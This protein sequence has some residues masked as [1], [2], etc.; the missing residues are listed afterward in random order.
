VTIEEAS[1]IYG[2]EGSRHR[3]REPDIVV[4]DADAVAREDAGRVDF[5]E[6]GSVALKVG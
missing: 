1:T 3:D 2:G 5:W 4:G 6:Y